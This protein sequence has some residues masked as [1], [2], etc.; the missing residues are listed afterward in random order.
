M[1]VAMIATGFWK[2][3][4]FAGRLPE[5]EREMP[6]LHVTKPGVDAGKRVIFSGRNLTKI[7]RTGELEVR[8]LNGVD[9]DL[10]EGEMPV[11]LG[12]SGSGKSTLL[13]ILGG[14]DRPT[15]GSVIFKEHNL[16]RASGCRS[17][18]SSAPSSTAAN[19][20]SR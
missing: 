10:Y 3:A 1:A 4:P 18:A 6:S 5:L 2:R 11:L 12:P 9:L 17:E 19:G 13:N 15:S 7:Y 14:L 20:N 16:T 8:A